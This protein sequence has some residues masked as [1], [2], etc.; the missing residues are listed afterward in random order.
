MVDY[1]VLV[2][3][4]SASCNYVVRGESLSRY[5]TISIGGSADI[6]A[7][8]QSV[9]ELIKV[10][11]ISRYH[12][13]PYF[14]M[15]C[16][17][18]VLVSNA[19]FR[20]VAVSTLDV[21]GVY[22][23]RDC[24]EDV[25]V[26]AFCGLRLST[27]IAFC[28]L[29]GLSGLEFAVGIPGSVGGAVTMNAGCFGKSVG[30]NVVQVAALMGGRLKTVS[31]PQCD[32]GYRKSTFQSSDSTV[33]SALF[34]TKKAD[35]ATVKQKIQDYKGLRAGQPTGRSAGSIF[36]NTDIYAGKIIE[37]AGLKGL[38]IGGAYVCDKHANFIINDGTASSDDVYELIKTI[39]HLVKERMGVTLR[40]EI[41][42]VG[43]FR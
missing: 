8:P 28:M 22:V 21:D 27:L 30:P 5:T 23:E 13:V 20:G 18:N 12:A 3:E 19:G 43:E 40:E 14:V 11:E 29:N 9:L 24:G 6:F 33:I 4:L 36:R 38:R 26:R 31:N 42:Y 16:G 2:N 17:S 32:F 34:R 35:S 15:G 25:Y 37:A 1:T 10:L 39:K 41:K 7:R